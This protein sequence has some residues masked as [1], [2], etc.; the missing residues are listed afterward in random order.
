MSTANGR[1]QCGLCKTSKRGMMVVVEQ[2]LCLI[3]A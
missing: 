1:E 3:K 2:A